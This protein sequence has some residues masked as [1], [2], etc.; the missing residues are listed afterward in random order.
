LPDNLCDFVTSSAIHLHSSLKVT[1]D[2]F[3]STFS[4][5]VHYSSFAAF[6]A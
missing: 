5:S 2:G 6:A 4:L 1:P 3:S